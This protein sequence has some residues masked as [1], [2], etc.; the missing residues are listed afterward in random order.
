MDPGYGPRVS[1]MDPGCA[2]WTQGELYEPQGAVL[3]HQ[4]TQG[5]VLTPSG[6]PRVVE[7]NGQESYLLL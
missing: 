5:A 6:Y 2:L 1:F 3:T 4:G 7:Y